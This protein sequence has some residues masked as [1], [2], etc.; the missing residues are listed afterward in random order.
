M[1]I[2]YYVGILISLKPRVVIWLQLQTHLLSVKSVKYCF[3]L[4]YIGLLYIDNSKISNFSKIINSG[5]RGLSDQCISGFQI[6]KFPFIPESDSEQ[7]VI[8]KFSVFF[9]LFESYG[10]V[11]G[12]LG[13]LYH[14]I[15]DIF[16]FYHKWVFEQS[17]TILVTFLTQNLPCRK[18]LTMR[19][20]WYDVIDFKIES[21]DF[22]KKYIPC[23]IIF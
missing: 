8:S 22:H 1:W 4:K 13:T 21:G 15:I 18:W 7:M 9:H 12:L 2:Y 3:F 5:L 17:L 23:Q 20:L 6:F 19:L 10:S 16:S 14:S 11:P